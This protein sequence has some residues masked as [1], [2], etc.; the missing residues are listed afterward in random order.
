[1]N[2]GTGPGGTWSIHDVARRIRDAD[3]DTDHALRAAV[4]QGS[5]QDLM[6]LQ[7]AVGREMNGLAEVVRMLS[8]LRDDRAREDE[9]KYQLGAQHRQARREVERESAP[10]TFSSTA[11][12][13]VSEHRGFSISGGA[14]RSQEF[15]G[16]IPPRAPP[17]GELR[18]TDLSAG[19]ASMSP[20]RPFPI[21]EAKALEDSLDELNRVYSGLPP[22]ERA[23]LLREA[24]AKRWTPGH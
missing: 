4:N 10:R 20:R 13:F 18:V 21:R 17:V 6:D 5:V 15:V 24:K 11:A 2:E 19:Y 8:R 7:E 22:E 9:E 14:R 3:R 12:E 23:K 16:R 1:M